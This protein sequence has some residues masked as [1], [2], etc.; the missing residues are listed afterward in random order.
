[1]GSVNKLVSVIKKISEYQKP[2]KK[3][4]Q[5]LIYL[6]ERKGI[7]LGYDFSIHYY[8]PYSSELDDAVHSMYIQGIVK[9]IPDG[10]SQRI[11]LTEISDMFESKTLSQADE[12]IIESVLEVFGSMTPFDLEVI[13]TT[14]FVARELYKSN[15]TCT[16]NII[17]EGVKKI[18]GDK[19]SNEKIQ[20]AISILRYNG[21]NW[22]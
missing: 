12:N 11:H 13:T 9:I 21:Y 7:V 18:K 6:I 3:A 16:D 14:D 19:F 8:G 2:S 15:K 20:G 4:L 5:K 17:I 22:Y 10:M 1:M